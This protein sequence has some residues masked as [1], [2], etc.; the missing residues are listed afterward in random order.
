MTTPAPA[1]SQPLAA[2][3]D[4]LVTY[5]REHGFPPTV[6]ELTSILDVSSTATVSARLR[7]L[8][9]AGLITRQ[10]NSGRAITIVGA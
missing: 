3:Y 6:R 10:P 4:A 5:T 2:T 9:N 1:L 7:G 8:E